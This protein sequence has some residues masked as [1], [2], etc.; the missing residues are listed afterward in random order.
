M[1]VC[2]ECYVCVCVMLV[3]VLCAGLQLNQDLLNQLKD[4]L[5]VSAQ[6]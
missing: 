2:T 5:S 6:L 3:C 1:V 4:L